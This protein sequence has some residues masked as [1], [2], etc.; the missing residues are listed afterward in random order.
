M[1]ELRGVGHQFDDLVVFENFNLK[2][3]SGD[4]LVLVGPSGSGKS[5][6]LKFMTGLVAPD[7]GEVFY[8][9]QLLSTLSKKDQQSFLA[10]VGMLF[11]Q[12]ALFDSMKVYDNL[13]FVL[14]EA[15]PDWKSSQR[16]AEIVKFL[17]A[18]GLD[19]V[20]QLF[21]GELSGGMQKRL[22]IARALVLQPKLVFYDDPTAGLDP[23]T[24]RQI[25]QMILDLKKQLN[26]TIV[27][28]THDMMR[29]YQLAGEIMVCFPRDFIKTGGKEETLH[30]SNAKVQQFIHG[31]VKGPLEAL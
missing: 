6:L 25:I 12:N 26:A 30:H 27:T 8:R 10:E 22:G 2:V 17:T 16:E 13:D 21:P 29:A 14:G 24:S 3:F 9:G 19:H 18:V 7:Q 23:I 1:I 5:L 31:D 20:P 4:S 15:K 11:Q 28:V